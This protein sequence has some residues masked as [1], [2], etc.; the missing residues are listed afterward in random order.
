MVS[1]LEYPIDMASRALHH[2]A[3]VRAVGQQPTCFRPRAPA[4]RQRQSV[5]GGK[6]DNSWDI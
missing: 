3:D 4:A 2:I 1:A 5:L 6:G